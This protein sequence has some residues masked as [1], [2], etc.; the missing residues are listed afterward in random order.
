M[1]L[2]KK[3]LFNIKIFGFTKTIVKIINYPS[4]K[5][6]EIIKKKIFKI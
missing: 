4:N 6:K 2:V 5:I 3:I 1:N